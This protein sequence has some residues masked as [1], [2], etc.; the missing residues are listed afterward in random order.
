MS[1]HLFIDSKTCKTNYLPKP[2][3]SYSLK[4]P[5][6]FYF[7]LKN[8][9]VRISKSRMLRVNYSL[10]SRSSFLICLLYKYYL[11]P[12]AASSRGG[13]LLPGQRP[14]LLPPVR[15]F[16]TY[17]LVKLGADDFMWWYQNDNINVCC[18][19]QCSALLV[20]LLPPYSKCGHIAISVGQLRKLLLGKGMWVGQYS[21]GWVEV[22]LRSSDFQ[23][24]HEFSP[25][26]HTFPPCRKNIL[27]YIC[28]SRGSVL[29]SWSMYHY[30]EE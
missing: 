18:P 8:Y 15:Y 21:S 3:N 26:Y 25:L 6:Y 2:E 5:A 4:N 14:W 19:V 29:A 11:R 20:I 24:I 23:M 28:C 16:P 27:K 1:S 12:E 30:Y 10:M 17:S 13:I 22:Q 7:L 9:P